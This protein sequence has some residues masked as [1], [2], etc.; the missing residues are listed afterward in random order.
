MAGLKITIDKEKYEI[1]LERVTLGEGRFLKREF[2]M[3]SFQRLD[4]LDPDPD[5]LVGVLAVCMKRKH[6]ELDDGEIIAKIEALPNG[7]YFDQA[8]KQIEEERKKLEDPPSPGASGDASGKASN[9]ATT[10]KTP[11]RR[12]TA[13]PA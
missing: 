4:L 12:S 1:D 7:N 6:P 11:G 13:K 9:G 2:G 3:E 8:L 5:L 10:P